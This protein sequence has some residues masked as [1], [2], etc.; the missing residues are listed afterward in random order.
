MA[1]I[2]LGQELL[3]IAGE[4]DRNKFGIAIG[5][6]FKGLSLGVFSL[7]GV[8]T[9]EHAK[10]LLATLPRPDYLVEVG[11]TRV[12]FSVAGILIGI[13][14]S[15]RLRVVLWPLLLWS[16]SVFAWS[17]W[18][19]TRIWQV[20]LDNLGHPMD[21]GNLAIYLVGLGIHL[22]WPLILAGHTIRSLW[23]RH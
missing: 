9:A 8:E 16:L 13:M 21:G 18:S 6:V 15:V 10:A 2:S 17:I 14:L 19:T 12:W 4:I 7:S 20:S 5:G 11:R 22:V 1:S 23:R 3:E